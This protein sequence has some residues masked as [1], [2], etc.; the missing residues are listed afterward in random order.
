VAAA[1]GG[2]GLWLAWWPGLAEVGSPVA[3]RGEFSRRWRGKVSMVVGVGGWHGQVD[4]C[5]LRL[6]GVASPLVSRGKFPRR[7]RGAGIC[8]C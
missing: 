2:G 4:C 3:R 7:W 1:S 8:G 6:V 5:R